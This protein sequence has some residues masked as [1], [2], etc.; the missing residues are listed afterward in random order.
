MFENHGKS[1]NQHC[2][3]SELYL[4]FEWT[5]VNKKCQK[6]PFWQVFEN[7]KLVCGQTVLPDRSVLIEQ[8]LVENAKIG[9]IKCDIYGDFQTLWGCP[10]KFWIQT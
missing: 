9:K 2:E 3:Q 7:L 8:K 5:K 10:Y 1:L 6:C 4:Q